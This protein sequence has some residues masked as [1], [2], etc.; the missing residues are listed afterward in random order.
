MSTKRRKTTG[1]RTQGRSPDVEPRPCDG[2]ESSE[3]NGNERIFEISA[4]TPSA[5]RGGKKLSS[6][7]PLREGR[8]S[9]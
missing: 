9:G 2:P 6:N 8:V 1:S 7:S 3:M 4:F 5:N